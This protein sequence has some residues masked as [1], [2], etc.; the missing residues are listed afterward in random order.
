[1]NKLF[2]TIDILNS[3]SSDAERRPWI[4]WIE[5]AG[6]VRTIVICSESLFSSRLIVTSLP[7]SIGPSW[8]FCIEGSPKGVASFVANV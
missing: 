5:T 2:L 7:I 1:M 3:E 6:D 4:P 8:L